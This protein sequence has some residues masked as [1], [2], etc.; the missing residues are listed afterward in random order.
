ME[1]TVKEFTHAHIWATFQ[2]HALKNN[3]KK[4]N[5]KRKSFGNNI[6]KMTN[7]RKNIKIRPKHIKA[8][9]EST[10]EFQHGFSVQLPIRSIIGT[11]QKEK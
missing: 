5:N 9:H 1:F 10:S 6:A 11:V 8:S 7:I 3:A 2:A 4:K